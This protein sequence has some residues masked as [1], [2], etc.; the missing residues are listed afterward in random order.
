VIRLFGADMEN[1]KNRFR[2]RK[3]KLVIVDEC[4]FYAALDDLITSVLAATLMDLQGTL[5]ITS[6]PGLTKRSLFY[7]AD[8]GKLKHLWSQHS[9][10]LHDNPFFQEP[11]KNPKYAT[12]GD[13]ELD[14]ICQTKFDGDRNHPEFRREYLGEWVFDE[15]ALVYPLAPE[16]V[17]SSL[18]GFKNVEFALGLNLSSPSQAGYVS[19][20]FSE[21]GRN[22]QVVDAEK[23]KLKNF[24]DL[25]RLLAEL[26]RLYKTDR[27][28]CYLGDNKPEILDSFKQRHPFPVQATEYDKIPFYQMIIATDMD[29][30]YVDVLDKCEDLLE[31][32]GS[33]VKDD[34]GKEIPTDQGT[35]LSDAF[36]AVY[37]NI[38][39]AYLKSAEPEETID[40]KMERQLVESALAEIEERKDLYGY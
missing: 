1:M 15:H 17:L 27:I 23:V 26:T 2:G 4:A 8:Q 16:N 13:E 31:E 30:G 40:Q 9:W 12:K 29:S 28:Y 22:S 19:L 34:N 18:R 33:T 24:N 11:S 38:Y 39:N 7:K 25:S 10:T 6:S 21:Y 36:F 37:L 14:I 20:A 3:F 5:V 32:F 35:P